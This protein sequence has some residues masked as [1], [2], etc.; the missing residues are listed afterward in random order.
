MGKRSKGEGSIFKSN[1]R[2]LWIA[3]IYLP[4]GKKKVKY[5]KTQ[6]EVRDWLTEQ[7]KL[8]KDGTYL[9]DE[10][11]TVETFL[12][13]YMEDVAA[14][15]LAPR[16]ILSYRN[17]VS[18]HIVPA[19][20]QVKLSQLRVDHLQ[21]LYS[22]KLNAGL[23]RRTVQYI[24]HFIHTVLEYA[25]KWGMVVRNVA[26]LAEPPAQDKIPAAVLTADQ[27]KQL[28]EVVKEDRLSSLYIC[29]VT[30]GLREGELLALTWPDVS[31]E[32]KT[33]RI[34]KQLQYIPGKGLSV[35]LPKTKTSIRTLPLPEVTYTALQKHFRESQNKA[36]LI[37]CTSVDTPFNPRNILRHFHATLK[38]MGLPIMPFHN[39]RHS[40]ASY[41][42]SAGTS[43]KLVSEL[44]GHSS[45]TITL[46]TYSHVLPGLAEESAKRMNT[47]FS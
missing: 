15:T 20:G 6:K 21:K 29:A 31:F 14:H 45:V 37:F 40:C 23:S 3:Q 10:S 35:K 30:L 9:T 4:T 33:I 34:D 43:P 24:H 38:K 26:D 41:H 13:R 8:I 27:A 46:S 18:K 39:L 11:H 42:L 7:K 47:I 44:L 32:N 12:S 22:D 2:E 25:V 1:S 5:A 28:F 16:T 36:G 19:I 17:L